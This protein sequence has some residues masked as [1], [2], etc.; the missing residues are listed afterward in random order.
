MS[1]KLPCISLSVLTGSVECSRQEYLWRR[2]QDSNP[3]HIGGRRV[4]SPL[5]H[6]CFPIWEQNL[7]REKFMKA[8]RLGVILGYYCHGHCEEIAKYKL[9]IQ[10]F[11]TYQMLKKISVR[12]NRVWLKSVYWWLAF[13]LFF[14]F[15]RHHCSFLWWRSFIWWQSGLLFSY[16]YDFFAGTYLELLWPDSSAGMCLCNKIKQRVLSKNVKDCVI[17]V[18]VFP[19]T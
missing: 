11:N 13:L 7:L 19:K 16:S 18:N 6:P 14:T 2:R 1:H 5:R 10:E 12:I 15:N 17:D 4:L 3:G 8:S 9:V